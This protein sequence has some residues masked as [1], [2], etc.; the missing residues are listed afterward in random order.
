[1]EDSPADAANMRLL[2]EFMGAIRET[3]AGWNM[4]APAAAGR[5]GVTLPRLND[6]LRGRINSFSLDA[7]TVLADRAGLHVQVKIEKAA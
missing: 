5:L 3:V 1:M 4:T 6:L 7:L 2:S